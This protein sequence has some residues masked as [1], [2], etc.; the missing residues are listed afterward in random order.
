M[1]KV[2]LLAFYTEIVEQVKIFMLIIISH[3]QVTTFFHKFIYIY[4]IFMYLLCVKFLQ[5]Y[6]NL[7]KKK[8]L[9]L[10]KLYFFGKE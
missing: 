3:T 1:V 4:T 8:N 10:Q 9:T 7:M 5:Y 2:L 6:N